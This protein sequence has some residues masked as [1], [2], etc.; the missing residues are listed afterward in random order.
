MINVYCK[1]GRKMKA[2]CK[3]KGRCVGPLNCKHPPFNFL[4]ETNTNKNIDTNTNM[5]IN[6]NTNANTTGVVS[7][8]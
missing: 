6:A 5:E 8:G 4:L 1:S 7:V 3:Y 2:L